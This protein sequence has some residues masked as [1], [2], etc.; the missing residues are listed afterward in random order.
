[1]TV[2]NATEKFAKVFVLFYVFSLFIYFLLTVVTHLAV[3]Y[4]FTVFVFCLFIHV[5][6]VFKRFWLTILWHIKCQIFNSAANW[7]PTRHLY[8]DVSD[9]FIDVMIFPF[10]KFVLDLFRFVDGH[11]IEQIKL[12]LFICP[13]KSNQD[14]CD[15]RLILGITTNCTNICP[16]WRVTYESYDV[17]IKWRLTCGSVN[18]PL[19]M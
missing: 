6:F 4:L 7:R 11:H 19:C 5:H 18:K 9:R 16:K 3:L 2:T 15:I 17:T 10:E 13:T 8:L 14:G 12:L 1:M